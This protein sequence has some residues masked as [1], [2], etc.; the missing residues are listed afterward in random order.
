MPQ[1]P[2]LAT[3]RLGL[4]GGARRDVATAGSA[5]EVALFEADR[6][7]DADSAPVGEVDFLPESSRRNAHEDKSRFFGRE[8]LVGRWAAADDASFFRFARQLVKRRRS[9]M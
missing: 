6:L 3:C 7:I 4:A 2:N 9:S 5:A 8:S 1:P